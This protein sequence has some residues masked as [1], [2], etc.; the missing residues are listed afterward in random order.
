MLFAALLSIGAG[1]GL[2][3][4]ALSHPA[5]YSMIMGSVRGSADHDGRA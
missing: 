5:V 3:V 4:G 1:V 2:A